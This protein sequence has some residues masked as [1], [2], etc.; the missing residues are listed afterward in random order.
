MDYQDTKELDLSKSE[1]I[2]FFLMK[3]AEQDSFDL[4]L[5]EIKEK[6]RSLEEEETKI[7]ERREFRD[8]YGDY[9]LIVNDSLISETLSLNQVRDAIAE[10]A[11]GHGKIEYYLT[12][13]NVVYP[14]DVQV[15]HLLSVAK[16]KCCGCNAEGVRLYNLLYSRRNS[17]YQ[18]FMI[19]TQSAPPLDRLAMLDDLAKNHPEE[20]EFILR[21]PDKK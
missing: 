16:A 4:R 2:V 18:C 6:K 12:G 1:K 20:R 3:R 5:N 11:P 19:C 14:T 10:A 17:C 8:H 7:L 9:T 21:L 13:L 15:R